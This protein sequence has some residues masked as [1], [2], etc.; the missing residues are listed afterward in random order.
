MASPHTQLW[1]AALLAIA[2]VPVIRASFVIGYGDGCVLDGDSCI[3]TAGF[4]SNYSAGQECEFAT[5][6]TGYLTAT[7]FHT[8]AGALLDDDYL[9]VGSPLTYYSGTAGPTNLFRASGTELA[10]LSGDAAY[11][12]GWRLCLTSRP[13]S[14]NYTCDAH[15]ALANSYRP[16]TDAQPPFDCSGYT[17]L[18]LSERGLTTFD[19][20]TTLLL[21]SCQNLER[22]YLQCNNFAAISAGAFEGLSSLKELYLGYNAGLSTI[23]AGGFDAL[24]NVTS[25]GLSYTGLRTIKAST[26]RGLVN[27]WRTCSSLTAWIW[28]A[29]RRGRLKG[30]E[31]CGVCI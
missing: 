5:T 16:P 27:I 9:V 19:A 30:W 17:S 31:S 1:F 23:T 29:L 3:T 24:G 14:T 10:W 28:N 15:Y 8:R 18:D 12:G 20:S 13:T 11:A 21:D 7:S 22:L 25:L 2:T 26:F 4:P 6:A